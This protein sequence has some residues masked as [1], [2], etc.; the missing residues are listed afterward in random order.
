MTWEDG[1][2]VVFEFTP[3]GIAKSAVAVGHLKLP[4]KPAVDAVKKAWSGYFDRLGQ[5]LS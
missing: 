5:F 3:K 2:V 1:A 4:D